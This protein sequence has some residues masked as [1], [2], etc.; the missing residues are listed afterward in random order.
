MYK[1]GLKLWSTNRNYVK[2]AIQLYKDNLYDYIEL[3]S[4]PGSYEKYIN[5]WKKLSV[6]YVIHAPHT[7]CGLNLA[8]KNSWPDNWPLIKEAL[9][10]ADALNSKIIIF[11]PGISGEVEEAVF[12]LNRINDSRIVIENKPYYTLDKA[13]ICNGHSPQDIKF[14]LE[15]TKVGFCFDIGPVSYTHLTLPTN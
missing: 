1:I 4:V 10:F 15:N 13:N 2:E 6:P 3:F 7:M 8:K 9:K 5:M 12:Q 11:H 14:I